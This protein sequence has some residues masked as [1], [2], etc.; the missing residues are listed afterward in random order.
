M[1]QEGKALSAKPENLSLIRG[2]QV[3]DVT[4]NS[5]KFSSDPLL[6]AP[7]LFPHINKTVS[8]MSQPG[9]D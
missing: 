3:V 4:I 9:K 1:A 8:E 6:M 5:C 2:T 7:Y